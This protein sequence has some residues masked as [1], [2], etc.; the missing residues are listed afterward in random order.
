MTEDKIHEIENNICDL[1]N[2]KAKEAANADDMQA[3]AALAESLVKLK[4]AFPYF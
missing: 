1:I 2:R 4:E 3:V